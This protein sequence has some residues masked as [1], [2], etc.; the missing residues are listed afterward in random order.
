MYDIVFTLRVLDNEL[1]DNFIEP[2]LACDFLR[3]IIIKCLSAYYYVD[4]VRY[5]VDGRPKDAD[6]DPL[7][8]IEGIR[9][10]KDMQEILANELVQYIESQNKEILDI[11]NSTQ[12]STYL[13]RVEAHNSNNET[14]CSY[15]PRTRCKPG[16][17][18]VLGLNIDDTDVYENV[19]RPHNYDRGEFGNFVAKLLSKYYYDDDFR[20]LVESD[21]YNTK[22]KDIDIPDEIKNKEFDILDLKTDKKFALIRQDYIRV[23]LSKFVDV[24][25][26]DYEVARFTQVLAKWLLFETDSTRLSDEE[27]EILRHTSLRGSDIKDVFCILNSNI[28]EFDLELKED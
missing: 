5:A 12:E 10:D 23:D 18:K 24:K 11:L 25:S 17:V 14:T 21:F 15:T 7:R 13:F 4:D 19:V 28:I 3:D 6:V 2:Y 1:V 27:K 20:A 8:I 22:Y 26:H 16:W 9:A